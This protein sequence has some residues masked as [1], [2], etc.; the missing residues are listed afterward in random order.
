MAGLWLTNSR[1]DHRF[2]HC[3]KTNSRP[4]IVTEFKRLDT[5]RLNTETDA[6]ANFIR[7]E[8]EGQGTVIGYSNIQIDRQNGDPLPDTIRR[9]MGGKTLFIFKDRAAA[10]TWSDRLKSS[11]SL[12]GVATVR[13]LEQRTELKIRGMDTLV[14]AED[15]ERVLRAECGAELGET[16]QVEVTKVFTYPWHE[17]AAMVKVPIRVADHLLTQGHLRVGWTQARVIAVDP[18]G[19]ICTKCHGKGHPARFCR[20]KPRGKAGAAPEVTETGEEDA[21]DP[22]E[23]NEDL[24]AESK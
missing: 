22:T 8:K 21:P 23:A 16:E 13:V 9:T 19:R 10:N 3:R 11:H 17:R 6:A 2:Y 7:D 12:R 20:T 1:R 24:P 5:V 14:E 4:E 18:N 15:V